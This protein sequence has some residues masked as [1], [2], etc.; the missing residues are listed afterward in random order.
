MVWSVDMDDFRGLCGPQTYP[1]L[2]MIRKVLEFQPIRV[3]N[4]IPA[5]PQSLAHSFPSQMHPTIPPRILFPTGNPGQTTPAVIIKLEKP[6]PTTTTPNPSAVQLPPV[7]PISTIQLQAVIQPKTFFED[8]PQP[9]HQPQPHQQPP[10]QIAAPVP[11]SPVVNPWSSFNDFNL[12]AN[13]ILELPHATTPADL[14]AAD[15]NNGL[16]FVNP[17][18]DLRPVECPSEGFYRNPEDCTRLVHSFILLVASTYGRSLTPFKT[19]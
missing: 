7:S 4:L 16:S 15:S 14:S 10:P 3:V 13:R 18:L 8:Q 2:R 19:H 11:I 12:L 1:L 6:G 9:Q 5:L 17:P